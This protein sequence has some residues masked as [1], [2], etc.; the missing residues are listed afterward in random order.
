M[1]HRKRLS[2]GRYQPLLPHMTRPGFDRRWVL[3]RLE[4]CVAWTKNKRV[5]V[6]AGKH[7]AVV[8]E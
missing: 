3:P 6:L 2:T 8:N 1:S 5:E 7:V 4:G